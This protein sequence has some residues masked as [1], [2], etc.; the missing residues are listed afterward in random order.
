MPRRLL[1]IT[2]VTHGTQSCVFYTFHRIL[3]IPVFASGILIDR[4]VCFRETLHRWTLA[5]DIYITAVLHAFY[6][7]TLFQA[8]DIWSFPGLI[9]IKRV[10]FPTNLD[11]S[12]SITKS[13]S[14]LGFKSRDGI[15]HL[16]CRSFGFGS[17]VRPI[18]CAGSKDLSSDTRI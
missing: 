1:M 2:G 5:M 11:P 16:Q 14:L 9:L 8:R 13:S 17:R 12:I 7:Y 15:A 6:G 3:L 4:L 18:E 10:I